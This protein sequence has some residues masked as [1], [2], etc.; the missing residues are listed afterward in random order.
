MVTWMS[1]SGSIQH[2]REDDYGDRGPTDRHDP[3]HQSR[4]AC[5]R[6][7]AA[8][9]AL[10]AVQHLPH[11]RL[12][13]QSRP[14]PAPRPI[15]PAQLQPPRTKPHREHPPRT[16]RRGQLPD[17]QL[18]QTAR[19]QRP[20]DRRRHR[21]G[22]PPTQHTQISVRAAS[23]QP[24]AD[25]P[26]LQTDTAAQRIQR[27]DAASAPAE[28]RTKNRE[29]PARKWRSAPRPPPVEGPCPPTHAIP[30]GRSRPSALGMNTLRVGLARYAPPL[31]PGVQIPKVLFE[32]LTRSPAT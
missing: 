32:I 12:S 14:A 8:R 13:L 29:S 7:P 1:P 31:D 5:A 28:T 25:A 19:T 18:P 27:I 10:R 22:P 21:T 9:S 20:M 4:S 16:H 24:T 17:R 3:T 26:S 30:S 2:P 23:P 11:P 6:R 15:P